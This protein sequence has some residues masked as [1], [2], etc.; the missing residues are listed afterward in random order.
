MY[1][2]AVKLQ[3]WD[4]Y[5]ILEM[6]TDLFFIYYIKKNVLIEFLAFYNKINNLKWN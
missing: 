2:K 5:T 1:H 6:V 3:I 4:G